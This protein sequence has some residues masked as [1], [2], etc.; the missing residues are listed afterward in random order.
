MQAQAAAGKNFGAELLRPAGRICFDG[1]I[2]RRGLQGDLRKRFY[3][4]RRIVFGQNFAESVGK[5]L[6]A[7]MGKQ[8]GFGRGNLAE[9][10]V[11]HAG[12]KAVGQFFY[13]INVTVQN[14]VIGRI[15]KQKFADGINQGKFGKSEFGGNLLF[16]VCF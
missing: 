16:N 10:G 7:G 8:V 14:R 12:Q 2:Q 6:F 4:R 15:H 11:G 13:Q 3:L 5:Y 1:N 9:N